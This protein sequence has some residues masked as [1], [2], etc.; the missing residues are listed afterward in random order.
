MSKWN[1]FSPLKKVAVRQAEDSFLDQA[2][3]DRDWQNLRFYS[4][5]DLEAALLEHK[6]FVEILKATGAEVVCLPGGDDLTLDSIY[7]R[8]AALVTP[9]GLILC[10]MGRESRR[11][12]PAL[13]GASLGGVLGTIEPPGTLEGGDFIW[14]DESTAAVGL[15]TRT[16]Q[17]GINQLKTFLGPEVEVHVVPLP[18]PA[19]PEDVFHLMSMISPVDDDLSVIYRPT[20]PESFLAWLEARGME[21]VEVPED[22]W[23]PMACNVLALGPRHV[24]MLDRLPKTKALLEATGCTVETYKGDEISRKG[25]GGPT[26]LTRPLIRG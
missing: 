6:N 14:L 4:A 1:E 19:H 3:I 17:E 13:H 8:D 7:V 21:F 5:P 23:L 10:H 11:N 2:R 26:C 22:E 24:L 9:K 25:E 18:P 15:G 20:M 12:E 16:N